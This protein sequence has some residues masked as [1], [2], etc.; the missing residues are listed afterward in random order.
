MQMARS[1]CAPLTLRRRCSRNSRCPEF[2]NH[3]MLKTY[4]ARELAALANEFTVQ[5]RFIEFAGLILHDFNRLRATVD[6]HTW[7]TTL[8]PALRNEPFYAWSQEA[9]ILRWSTIRPRGY[10]GDAHLIDFLYQSDDIAQEV[11]DASLGGQAVHNCFINSH[12][13]RSVRDRRNYLSSQIVRAVV[14][15]Q[16]ARILVLACGH[17]REGDIII[18]NDAFGNA[19]IICLD[20]DAI[21]CAEVERRFAKSKVIVLN[22]NVTSVLRFNDEK[23]D[24]IY[25]AGLYDYLPDNVAV[26][27][28]THFMS[29]LADSGRLIVPNFLKSDSN[30]GGREL[31][32]D[33]FLIHRDETAIRSLVPHQPHDGTLIYFEDKY[34]TIGYAVFDR[35]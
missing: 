18:G 19:E 7:Q 35:N 1:P 12:S 2:G 17:F 32:A 11:L 3:A 15:K 5:S 29:L 34:E 27:F 6:E 28:N 16:N 33:W 13:A 30:R 23:F 20:Q 24:L 25:A 14:R 10:A 26:R 22:K 4:T 21:S 31:A 9:P 8:I